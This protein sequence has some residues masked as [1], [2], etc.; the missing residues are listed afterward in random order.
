MR[1]RHTLLFTLSALA[2]SFLTPA[3]AEAQFTKRLKKAAESAVKDETVRQVDRIVEDAV[4]CAFDD[5][6]CVEQAERDGKPV[7][8]TDADGNILT[9][10]EGQPVTDRDQAA[11]MAGGPESGT[12]TPPG[13]GR[14]GEGVW[15]NY[16]FV[17]GDEILFADDFTDDRVG[18]FPQRLEFGRG[19]MEIVEWEGGRYLRS[20]S[21]SHFFVVLPDPLPEKFTIEF[22]Y[23]QG[24]GHFISALVTD[25]DQLEHDQNN[26]VRAYHTGALFQLG[27]RTGVGGA[28]DALTM[29]KR[30]TEGMTAIRIQ[31]DGSYAKM[32]TDE[33]RVANIPN[34]AI[35]RGNRL[36]FFVNGAQDRPAYVGNIVIAGGGRDLYDALTTEGRFATYGILFDT[37][38]ANL[39]PESTGTLREIGEMLQDH[40]D[41]RLR[42]E[43]HTDAEGSDE[44]NLRLSGERAQAV[45]DYLVEEFDIAADRLAADGLGESVPVGDNAT[46][47]G[48]QQ[49]RRVELVVD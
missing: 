42:I 38:S 3:T 35:E 26:M 24:T 31:V 22:D 40:E 13:G 18:N 6:G 12:A 45:V 37:N 4:A 49:N 19:N 34:A 10:S 16:D 47:S 46:A 1:L 7:V 28:S 8:Y 30:T 14:P 25:A 32:Y 29:T 23:F 48:R 9:D 33:V 11:Q 21:D 5:P 2:V 44:H 20:T 36:A 27:N 17:R 43:G 39:R 15:S 41:L